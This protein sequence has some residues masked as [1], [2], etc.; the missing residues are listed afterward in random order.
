MRRGS[1][2][3][4]HG[5]LTRPPRRRRCRHGRSVESLKPLLHPVKPVEQA[6][7]HDFRRAR[8]VGQA[9]QGRRHPLRRRALRR[10]RSACC[11]RPSR[12]AS[13]ARIYCSSR[14]RVRGH[15]QR[16]LVEGQDLAK[17]V[18][19]AH[20]DDGV[21]LLH[22]PLDLVV[23]RHRVELRLPGDAL[24]EGAAPVA[25]DEG[26]EQDERRACRGP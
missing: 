1:C 17:G 2:G 25:V 18:V 26:A 13:T 4:D 8:L 3:D 6:G 14:G 19:A 23:E 12:S 22:Q 20:G 5:T 10:S 7:D 9:A 16:A 15:D 21:R 11:T 24:Q